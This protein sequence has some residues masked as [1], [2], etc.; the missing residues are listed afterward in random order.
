MKNHPYYPQ[1][2]GQVEAINKILENM[3]QHMVGVNK[4]SW[5]FQLFS[6]LWAY[7]TSVKTI[8]GFTPF[9]LVYWIKSMLPIECDIL[10]LKL[11]V[12]ILIHTS[13]EEE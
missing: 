10:S 5:N 3:L 8:I 1:E 4:T 9:W 7:K 6:A 2:N 13:F 11:T 12:E